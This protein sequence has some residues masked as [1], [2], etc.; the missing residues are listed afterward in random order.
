[1]AKKINYAGMFTL[2][3]DGRY[4]GSYTDKTGR[5]YL[6]DRDPEQLYYK[7]Q[8][9]LPPNRKEFRHFVKLLKTGRGNTGKK[10]QSA[11]GQTT[12]H[13]IMTFWLGTGKSKSRMFPPWKL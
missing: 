7:L 2:R 10:S 13:T 5:H 3:K 11:R 4:Q 6:Y 9:P 8:A 1:M 12:S